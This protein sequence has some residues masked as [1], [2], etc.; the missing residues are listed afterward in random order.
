L[1]NQANVQHRT[2]S[3]VAYRP[4]RKAGKQ[5]AP[6]RSRTSASWCHLGSHGARAPRLTASLLLRSRTLAVTRDPVTGVGRRWL[7][8][9]YGHFRRWLR[10]GR[11]LHSLSLF[12]PHL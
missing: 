10:G 2:T 6:V 1:A 9:P 3:F 11:P 12:C 4:S 5:K 7:T 8:H